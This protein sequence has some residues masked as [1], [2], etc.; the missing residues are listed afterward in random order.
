MDTQRRN[1]VAQWAFDTR[2]ILGRF[3]L[4]LE[5][6]DEDWKS[7]P[8]S[9]DFSFTGSP[10]A[11]AFIMANAVTALG[12][13]LFGRYGEGKGKPKPILN[14]VKKDAD[15]ISAYALSEGLWY[16]TRALPENHAVMIS[17][18]EGLMPKAGETPEMGSNPQLGFGRVYAR[19]Q[20]AH[21]LDR[22]VRRL[23]NEEGY[24]W[25]QFWEE[26]NRRGITVWGAAVVPT[27]HML[28]P[29]CKAVWH[30]GVQGTF[31]PASMIA[32]NTV[33]SPPL[34]L[35]GQRPSPSRVDG[36]WVRMGK[37]PPPWE[38]RPTKEE[39]E[40]IVQ[41]AQAV[42]RE[43]EPFEEE[44]AKVTREIEEK[45]EALR[46]EKAR[47]L[48]EIDEKEQKR[49]QEMAKDEKYAEIYKAYQKT[50]WTAPRRMKY[51]AEIWKALQADPSMTDAER[52]RLLRLMD[53]FPLTPASFEPIGDK[54]KPRGKTSPPTEVFRVLE[55]MGDEDG[56][57]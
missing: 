2:S 3:H 32:W 43:T 46:R 11:R 51:S 45:I 37:Q 14:Q 30:G 5:D 25:E 39:L 36:F 22:C 13:R 31:V 12:T 27:A 24:E 35:L 20:V 53:R 7:G 1:L 6:V 41:L 18:G 48:R 8:H 15:A 55:E 57:K 56:K 47:R 10:L 26:I 50:R 42:E 49:I 23:I 52:H 54:E 40:A 29:T 38:D 34:A 44:R 19:P 21:V 9:G 28:A 4:W 17:L 16:L 33:A